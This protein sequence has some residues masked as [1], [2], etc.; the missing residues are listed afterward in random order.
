MTGGGPAWPAPAVPYGPALARACGRGTQ[1]GSRRGCG[2]AP[3]GEMIWLA[4]PPA[5]PPRGPVAA[6]AGA[7]RLTCGAVR[8]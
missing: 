7:G 3:D 4:M 6:R 8:W 2:M 5:Q 1:F